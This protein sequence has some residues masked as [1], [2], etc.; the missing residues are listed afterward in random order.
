MNGEEPMM[1]GGMEKLEDKQNQP[2]H[3][4]YQVS[5]TRPYDPSQEII[6]PPELKVRACTQGRNKLSTGDTG[7]V[8]RLGHTSKL[9]VNEFEFKS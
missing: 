1:D 8:T 2:A 7:L 4:L 9:S 6:F 5:N 3:R